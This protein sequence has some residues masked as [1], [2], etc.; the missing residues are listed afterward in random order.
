MGEGSISKAV[1]I[2]FDCAR[3]NFTLDGSL[4]KNF[5]VMDS[6]STTQNF[7]TSHE[8]IVGTG[9]SRVI[10]ADGSVERTS[11]DWVAMEHVEIGIVFFPD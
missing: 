4:F 7:L 8:E 11:A 5:R 9:V 3:V 2:V 6:L 1:N 10:V